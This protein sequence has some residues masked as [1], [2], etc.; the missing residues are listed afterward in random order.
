VPVPPNEEHFAEVDRSAVKYPYDPQ[1]TEQLMSEAGFAKDGSGIWSNPQ[2]GRFSAELAVFQSPQNESEMSIIASQWRQLGF[3]MKELVW[4]ANLARD[5]ALRNTHANLSIT[6]GPS[7]ESTL[8]EY[9]TPQIPKAETRWLG[10]NR[11]GWSNPEFDRLVSAY[12]ATLDKNQRT[13]LLAQ[14]THV[15]SDDVAVISLYFNPSVAAVAAGLTGPAAVVPTSNIAWNIEA[16]E[17][18]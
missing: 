3:D 6:S 8:V 16:W 15:F 7:G 14:M 11:G 18:R 12:N 17:L 2:G 9:D 1:R 10:S 5:N 13:Q 4:A